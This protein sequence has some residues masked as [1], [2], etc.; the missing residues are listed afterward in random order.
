MGSEHET[1]LRLQL[2]I[3][4]A[5]LIHFILSI[6]AYPKTKEPVLK[7]IMWPP[8]GL[9]SASPPATSEGID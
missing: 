9:D 8:A 6:P 4:M 7:G 2:T 3:V 1:A 5:C